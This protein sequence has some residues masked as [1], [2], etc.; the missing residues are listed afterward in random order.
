MGHAPK[1]AARQDNHCDLEQAVRETEKNSTDLQL[2]KT[3]S[4]NDPTLLQ[5]L[6]RLGRQQHEL[7]RDDYQ[8]HKKKLSSRFA[9]V[10]IQD[11]IIVPKNLRT[12]IFSLLHSGYP[13]INKRTIAAR[14]SWWPRMTEA[15]QKKCESCIPCKM[16]GENIR[17]NIPITETNNHPRLDSP[18]EEI[19]LDFIGPITE[20]NHRFYLTFSMVQ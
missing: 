1:I 9:L 5:T 4:T 20:N 7:I 15:I 18:N 19:Q 6:V 11:K 8:P 2:L 16:S 17:P 3:D 14:H 13:A 12:T 10:F